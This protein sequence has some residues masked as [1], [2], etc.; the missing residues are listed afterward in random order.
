MT[1][2]F[3]NRN[4]LGGYTRPNN[5]SRGEVDWGVQAGRVY[6]ITFQKE[7][8]NGPKAKR[9]RNKLL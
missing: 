4:F 3:V 7:K 1:L 5:G 9:Q 6:T 2:T 8:K